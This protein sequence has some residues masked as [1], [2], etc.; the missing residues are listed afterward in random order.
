[1]AKKLERLM[2]KAAT[3]HATRYNVEREKNDLHCTGSSVLL[4]RFYCA[5]RKFAVNMRMPFTHTLC[6]CDD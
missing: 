2:E 6:V 4:G 5:L 3:C 1:M